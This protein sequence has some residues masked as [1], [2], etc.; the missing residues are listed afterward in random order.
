[1]VVASVANLSAMGEKMINRYDAEGSQSS[2]EPGSD[3]QVLANKLGITDP[4]DMDDAELVLLE[5][6][7]L[8]V[9]I[10][11]LP[12]RQLTIQDLADWHRRWLGNL[13]PWAG[14]LRSVNMGKG[15]FTFAAAPQIPRLLADFERDCLGRFTP[16]N[17]CTDEELIKAIALSHVEFILIHPFRE[18]NGRLSR[19]LADVMAVQGGRV[20]LDYSAWEE[21][22]D[23]YFAAINQ[24]L[25]CN[26]EPMEYW[27]R[28][29]LLD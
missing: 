14:D 29:A 12:D 15:G 24:G 19:L 21:H 4:Q 13:Y 3:E 1:M 27:V 25:S 10:E 18:G 9:L 17:D 26:Y 28:Q 20:P 22:K 11:D 6:L 5:K 23:A 7:Y 8:S 2:Y 16:C